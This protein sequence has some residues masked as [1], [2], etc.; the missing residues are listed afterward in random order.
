[1]ELKA[2]FDPWFIHPRLVFSLLSELA[3]TRL[4][5]RMVAK[6]A[7][8]A[9]AYNSAALAG[10]ISE[11][12]DT[13]R[14]ANGATEHVARTLHAGQIVWF[15][16]AF[17]FKGVSQAYIAGTATGPSFRG[18][19]DVADDIT[20]RGVFNPEYLTSSSS[21][22]HLTG[23]K[24][25]FLLCRV[26]TIENNEIE[27]TPILLGQR[28]NAE[29]KMDGYLRY[30]IGIHPS[31]IDQFKGVDFDMGLTPTDLKVLRDVS[32]EQ[33]KN[34]FADIIKEPDRPKDWG[35]EQFDLWTSRMTIEGEHHTA[36]IM[37]KGPAAFAPMKISHLG[38][39]GDQIDRIAQTAA[40]L[41]VVQHCHSVTA[42]VHNMLHAYASQPG[43]LRRYMVIDGFDTIRILRHYGHV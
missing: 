22:T 38:K 35:G 34:W 42:P 26:G 23:R 13:H 16:Q 17:Y 31:K 33:V 4:Q 32:E 41:L 27:V 24:N 30:R 3:Q 15:E 19:L 11:Y 10:A 43:N 25:Q 18:K 14:V 29:D 2:R 1:M 12:T 39:N 37:F 7:V 21:V 28:L 9:E 20:V 5:S 8:F 36:A 40:D 6:D